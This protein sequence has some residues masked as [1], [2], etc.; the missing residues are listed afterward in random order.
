LESQG[1][2]LLLA[3]GALA[4]YQASGVAG[5]LLSG[6]FSDRLGRLPVLYAATLSSSAFLT[7]FMHIQGGWIAPMLVILGFLNL[8]SQPVLLALVQDKFPDFRA[9][10]NGISM[11]INFLSLSFASIAIGWMG[12]H[13]GLRGAFLWSAAI[14]LVACIGL[15]FISIT[16]VQAKAVTIK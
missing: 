2:S 3:G 10:A 12:D 15:G 1:A 4:L 13:M 14:N 16:K 11:A 9:V 5:A 7:I 6:T 8:A